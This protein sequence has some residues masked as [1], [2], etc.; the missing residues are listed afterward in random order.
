MLCAVDEF[1]LKYYTFIR[2]QIAYFVTTENEGGGGKKKKIKL[3]H[4]HTC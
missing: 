1:T 2:M 3:S 4:Q